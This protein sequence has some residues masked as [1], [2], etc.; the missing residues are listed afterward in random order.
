MIF[1]ISPHLISQLDFLPPDS[2]G[3]DRGCGHGGVP[4]PLA[5]HVQRNARADRMNAI[6]VPQA[7]GAGM[8]PGN[9]G[10]LHHLLDPAI[11]RRSVDP[12]AMGCPQPRTVRASL[13]AQA[14]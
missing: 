9:P 5:E 13:L 8:P 1:Y 4:H 6:A 3:V 10:F 14:D 2:T 12:A 11:G 7:L